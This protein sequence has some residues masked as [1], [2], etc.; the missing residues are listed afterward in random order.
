MTVQ[1]SPELELAK[2]LAEKERRVRY[3]RLNNWFPDEGP[4]RRE[5]YGKHI[6]FMT[7][8]CHYIQ[9]AF[10]AANQ[11]GK[12][13]TGA[14]ETACHLTGL[15]PIWYKGKR[16]HKAVSGWGASKTTAVTRDGVQRALLGPPE[17]IGSGMIPK[18]SIVSIYKKSGSAAD[19]VEKITVRHISGGISSI[20][21]K[22]YDMGREVF[23]ASTLDFI[24]LDEEPT[25]PGVYSECLTRV[26]ATE[27]IIYCTFTPLFGM[28]EVVLGYLKEGLLPPGGIGESVPGKYVVNCSWDDVPHLDEKRKNTLLAAY[29]NSE[30]DARTKGLPSLGAGAIYP[31][32]EKEFIVSPF[33]IPGHWPLFYGL[34]VGY[35]VTSAI[36][37]AEQPETGTLYVFDE[38]YLMQ[39]LPVLHASAIKARGSFIPGFIDP[40]SRQ[41][42]DEGIKLMNVYMDQ[43]LNIQMAKNAVD[44]GLV[45]VGQ[46]FAA[47][48]LK[49]FS[50]CSKLLEE[51][52]MYHR[53]EKGNIVKK[54]DHAVDA[55][56][57]AIVS[58]TG[59]GVSKN[60]YY[61][62]LEEE[63]NFYGSQNKQRDNVTG[64]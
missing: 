50:T 58:G 30:R 52:R 29:S 49:I 28:S 2:L 8:G 46:Y 55:L 18:A 40:S 62:D 32:N 61:G 57:Y 51:L 35:N 38:H 53:D 37:V 19:A 64:Y 13:Q 1:K 56:R 63:S 33:E 24:W 4:Y 31:Y 22:S 47:G 25:D 41:S 60:M 26:V 9:R 27:G 34:D 20:I 39:S 15:Y 16:F 43:G 21:F 42:N 7:A 5:L 11:S 14:F 44:A 54:L 12:T 59:N 23:Q 3:D 36:W 48:R 10:I 17:D 45:T 6:A